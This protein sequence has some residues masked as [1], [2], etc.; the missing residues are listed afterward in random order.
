MGNSRE[1]VFCPG[2]GRDMGVT[3]PVFIKSINKYEARLFC[4]CGWL[5]PFT[6]AITEEEAI[7]KAFEKARKRYK[8]TY[9]PHLGD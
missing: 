9:N 4:P 1:P 5:A 6:T 8:E 3:K 7:D 2:C